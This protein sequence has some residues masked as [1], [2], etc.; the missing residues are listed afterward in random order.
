MTTANLYKKHKS[1]KISR[2]KFL[3]EVRRDDN[4]PWITNVTSYTDA[5]KI[6]KNK[7]I[8]NEIHTS[9]QEKASKGYTP[10][11]TSLKLKEVVIASEMTTQEASGHAERF[12][13]YMSDKEGKTFTVTGGSVDGPSFDLDLDGK[14]Y[15]GGSYIISI[16]GEILNVSL[17]EHPVYA[18]TKML[19]G[20][21]DSVKEIISR[22]DVNKMDSLVKNTELKQLLDKAEVI[23]QDL[24]D[25]GGFA[26]QDC[27]DYLRY[28]ISNEF[29]GVY[30]DTLDENFPG[31]GETIDAKDID[32]DLMD[33]F[34]RTNKKLLINTKTKKGIKG[35][36][37]KMYGDLVF[38]G[39]DIRKKDIV[40]V[41]I[42]EFFSNTV[43]MAE[44]E[45]E[46]KRIKKENPG[47]KVTYFFTKDD[48]KGY[49]IQIKATK[50]E[51]TKFHKKLDTLV[52]NTFGKRKGEME[53]VVN[54][55]PEGKDKIYSLISQALQQGKLTKDAQA[56][57][58]KWMADPNST[59][60][61]II[62]ALESITGDGNLKEGELT[63]ANVPSNIKAFAKRRGATS[64]VN[65]IAGW[66][67]KAGRKIGG[68]VAI[69]KNY[70]TL[71]LDL[72]Y[73]DG[74]IHI[75]LNS[76]EVTLHGEPVTDAKSFASVLALN[77]TEPDDDDVE[78]DFDA[79]YE[80]PREDFPMSEVFL[81][82]T[83]NGMSNSD[84][85]I[86][87]I[88]DEKLDDIL[89]ANHRRELEYMN[90]SGDV[91]YILPTKE[92]DRFIDYADSSGYDVDYENSE[93][94]VINIKEA[95][96][97][98]MAEDLSTAKE[99]ELSKLFDKKP[100]DLKK[101]Y[102]DQQKNPNASIFSVK[103]ESTVKEHHDDPNFPK[104]KG[105]YALLDGIALD[106]GKGDLYFE[107][108]DAIIGFYNEETKQ[109]N[110]G[111]IAAVKQILHDW[112][113]LEQYD[114]LLGDI[115]IDKS[116]NTEV[117]LGVS[118]DKLKGSIKAEDGVKTVTLKDFYFIHDA[119]KY[120]ADLKVDFSYMYEPSND[121]DAF[122]EFDQQIKSVT[123]VKLSIYNPITKKLEPVNSI[124][125]MEHLTD[126]IKSNNDIMNRIENDVTDTLDLNEAAEPKVVDFTELLKGAELEMSKMDCISDENYIKAT[127][128]AQKALEKN[129]DAYRNLSI[130]NWTE[131]TKEDEKQELQSVKKDN[132]V[133]TENKMKKV[134]TIKESTVIVDLISYL[135][136]KDL[137][138]E[139]SHYNYKVGSSVNTPDGEGVVTEISGGTLTIK[140][141]SG[142]K[143]DYQLNIIDKANTREGQ[144]Y[145]KDAK[146]DQDKYTLDKDG[147]N[148]IIRVAIKDGEVFSI[149]D[150]VTTKDG[151][152]IK[153]TSF[154]EEQSKI[155]AV[156]NT[157]MFFSSIDIEGLLPTV[158]KPSRLGVD[159]MKD[160][161]DKNKD[162][163]AVLEKLKT[164]IKSK[165]NKE[166]L[167]AKTGDGVH[168][169]EVLKKISKIP[170]SQTK[171]ELTT[172]F[173]AG[174][175]IDI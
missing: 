170:N 84:N 150:D 111:G 108:E 47:K 86:F 16:A 12:A 135:K 148:K 165:L 2:E 73:Q 76:E 105:V 49:K 87:S 161:I 77:N 51:E 124:G 39:D 136:K 167:T 3:Y 66:A 151:E 50:E 126:V 143:Q 164:Y 24:V 65:K 149:G 146:V 10:D 139:D 71:V 174:K 57:F 31:P 159:E 171:A 106:W 96:G 141:E 34:A 169:A 140:M 107:V 113:V 4:L 75:N 117:D 74:A 93:D 42:L 160:L 137:I 19:E 46:L 14:K 116:L 45:F 112:D 26:F 7:G 166:A 41:E 67:E 83:L 115:S 102:Q 44:L 103:K 52:H 32:Y 29:T 168:D 119:G 98:S 125:A 95:S 55:S 5:I 63:E 53:E 134:P 172:A 62:K 147:E 153:I 25:F 89:H 27:V 162:K 35:S 1:G 30:E 132:F 120:S 38:N 78:K 15:E 155:K 13:K 37:G 173:K 11:G 61:A 20:K 80:E 133:D 152:A 68:G 175:S 109:F 72:G 114:H 163:S 92:F 99:K 79:D 59:E 94:S 64:L 54:Y 9:A 131:I 156:Y 101:K 8:I 81:E 130:A 97:G 110:P 82:Q 88:N 23:I 127:K 145:F 100:E 91:Y 142:N 121:V 58:M 104:I 154:V 118:F 69:G 90:I 36:V 56:V 122:G 128:K 138:N 17:P 6:L 33:Y 40:S 144:M 18:N 60:E 157:G 158:A 70:N 21:K 28:R 129:S 85:T 48:P 22:S 123:I 43:D